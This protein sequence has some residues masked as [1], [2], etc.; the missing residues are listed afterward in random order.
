MKKM[1]FLSQIKLSFNKNECFV[2]KKSIHINV[3]EVNGIIY[4]KSKDYFS[5]NRKKYY[6]IT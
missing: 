6:I 4:H 1:E 2:H 5:Q 3:I